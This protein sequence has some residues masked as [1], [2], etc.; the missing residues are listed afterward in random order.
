MLTQAPL[1]SVP[2]PGHVQAPVVQVWPAAHAVP[3]VP[4]L[5]VSVCRFTQ[6]F[7]HFV[8]PPAQLTV[9]PPAEQT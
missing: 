7:P 5:A 3:Q 1:Q 6:E 8:V 2:P 4:Q 9:H